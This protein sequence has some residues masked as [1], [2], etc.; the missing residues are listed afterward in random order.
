MLI[1]GLD[2]SGPAVAAALLREDRVLAS[3]SERA[4]RRGAPALG[5][6]LDGLWSVSG[7]GPADLEGIGVAT[8]PGSYSAI[9]VGE[10]AA[11][12][13]AAA[14]GLPAQ[15]ISTHEA[16]ARV[17][18]PGPGLLVTVLDAGRG[19]VW[20][21][22]RR[23]SGW[24]FAGLLLSPEDLLARLPSEEARL[25]GPGTERHR[26]V[27]EA[28]LGAEALLD[29]PDEAVAEGVALLAAPGLLSGGARP[30]ARYLRPPDAALPG[31]RG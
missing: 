8:G 5:R 30:R 22:G 29:L 18:P 28:A 15:G 21:A 16:L 4:G 20:A 23:G 11:A 3:A 10:G 2:T 17:A 9:R 14:L 24:D 26:G 27:F 19:E 1:L 12:G 13:L 31:A 25:L 7:T 6:L